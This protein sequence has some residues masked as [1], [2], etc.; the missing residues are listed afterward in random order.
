MTADNAASLPSLPPRADDSHKGDFGRVLLVGGSRAMGGG[1]ALS[2]M[3]ALRSGAGLV[4]LAVPDVCQST[5]ASFDPAYMTVGLPSDGSGRIAQREWKDI[6]RITEGPDVLGCGP[7][8]GRS[9][10]L[11]WLVCRL[12]TQFPRTMVVDADGLNAL[13]ERPDSLGASAGPRILTPHPGEFRRLAKTDA[14]LPRE[15]AESR[16]NELAARWG[17]VI[18]LKGHR[19]LIT[20]GRDSFTNPT[21]NPGMATGG[22]GDVLT[23]VVSALAAGG[24]SPLDA[25][26]LGVYVHGLAGD[27]AAERF[28][29]VSLTAGDV[30]FCLPAAFE[31]L[32]GAG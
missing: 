18:V 1:I 3:A 7:G 6:R 9:L 13:A 29:Q 28:G 27:I 30:A 31:R 4:E 14:K 10:G 17:A 19:T 26:R 21:G 23:G 5:V 25:A 32:A 11:T 20:D 15:E 16:A 24:L 22:T 2:G 12:Y 8:L